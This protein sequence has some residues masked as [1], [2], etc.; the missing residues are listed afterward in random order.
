[1]AESLKTFFSP[2]LVRRLAADIER[3]HPSFPS[4]LFLR[5]ATRGLDELE[6]LDRGKHITRALERHLP[7]HFPDAIDI[8]LRSLGPEHATDELLGVGMAPFYYLPHTQFVATRGLDHFELSMRAQYELTKRFSAESSIRPFIAADPERTLATLREWARDPNAHVRRLVSEG[9]RLRL[10]W[11]MR[12]A[13]LDANPERV[14]ELLEL[15][16]DDPTPLVRRSVANSLNDLGKVHPALLTRTCGA[17]LT[18]ASAERRALIEHALRSA[19]KRG[20][21]AALRLLGYGK[22]AAVTIDGVR[23]VPKRVAIGGSVAVH[24]VVT[25]SS[26][27]KQELLIDLGVHFVKAGGRAARKVFKVKRVVLSAGEK[28]ALKKS[29]S[30]ALHTTRKPQPGRHGVD[31]IVNGETTRVGQFTVTA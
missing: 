28:V 7:A 14:L 27:S 24:F 31:V 21:S 11:A 4:R 20:D 10:P 17:W 26:R 8:L 1:M 9:T 13:W 5:D 30:L 25:S 2:T 29:I 6:L 3:V 23:L 18:E 19:V 22:K 16:K 15:L 12:V